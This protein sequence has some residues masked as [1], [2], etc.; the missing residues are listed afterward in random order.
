MAVRSCRRT[1]TPFM[2]NSSRFEVK[3]ARN[4]AL[5]R[6]GVRLS[7]ASASTRSLKSSQLR[8]RS[9]HTSESELDSSVL[10]APRSPIDAQT[11]SS[12]AGPLLPFRADPTDYKRQ[13][14]EIVKSA[15]RGTAGY[16]RDACEGLRASSRGV[17]G[18]VGLGPVL[19]LSGELGVGLAVDMR[20]TY[21]QYTLFGPAPDTSVR[22]QSQQL[23]Q[24]RILR[25]S[26][27]VA[28]PKIC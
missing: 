9:S 25:T 18:L 28:A 5:S 13:C 23:G 26:P 20:P 16:R 24:Y 15:C 6:S 7:R 4:F 2:K 8:S 3:M 19:G 22:P 17:A 12:M 14:G 27:L 21:N 1:A 10:R 11:R